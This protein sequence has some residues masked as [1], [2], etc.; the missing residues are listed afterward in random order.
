MSCTAGACSRSKVS[1]RRNKAARND[2]WDAASGVAWGEAMKPRRLCAVLAV[3]VA[4]VGL[5]PARVAAQGAGSPEALQAAN[6]LI[7]CVRA[8]QLRCH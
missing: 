2:R 3:V 7:S 8:P 5:E 4:L 1:F 6:E